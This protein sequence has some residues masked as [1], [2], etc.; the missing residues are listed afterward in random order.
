MVPDYPRFFL[1][2]GIA[3]CSFSRMSSVSGWFDCILFKCCVHTVA[4]N[5]A[6]VCFVSAS[7]DVW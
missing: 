7:Y 6:S 1:I 5:L 2:D 4:G 3:C